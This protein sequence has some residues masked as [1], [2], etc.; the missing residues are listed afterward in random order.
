MI[1]R[2]L[3]NNYK[4]QIG[5]TL[6]E[7]LIT[8]SIVSIGALALVN[9]QSKLIRANS[10]AYQ[11]SEAMVVA[12]SKMEQ[13][14]NFASEF[15]YQAIESGTDTYSG[16]NTSYQRS[17]NVASY[18]E[19]EYKKIIL[20]VTWNKRDGSQGSII[21]DSQIAKFDA[22]LSGS[23]MALSQVSSPLTPP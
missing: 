20:E 1:S 10:I 9:L 3:M 6:I 16:V 8:V 13:L 23:I 21:L 15:D 11:S 4:S 18:S 2:K 17:W 12:D 22:Q 5:S 7:A 14:R 19:P